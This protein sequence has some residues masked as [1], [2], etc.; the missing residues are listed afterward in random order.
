M[1]TY[2]DNLWGLILSF[3]TWGLEIELR[4]SSEGAGSFLH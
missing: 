1:H 4:S 3:L 2:E